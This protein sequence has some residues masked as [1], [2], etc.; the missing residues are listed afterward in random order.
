MST[1]NLHKRHK[2]EADKP[3]FRRLPSALSLKIVG[4]H[5]RARAS[6][7]TLPHGDVLTPVFM[8]VGTQGTI[9]GLTPEQMAAPPID[10]K[11][12][13]ANTYHLA[14]RPGTELVDSVGGIHEFMQWPRNVLTDSGGFQMVSL[15]KLCEITE[16]GVTFESF[17]DGTTMLLTPEMS[18]Q[19][20]NRIGSD[21]I[22]AL[23][24]VVSSVSDDTARF[25]EACDRT[26]RWIDRCMEAHANPERQN[27]FGIVQGGLDVSEGGLRD[28]CL[29][30]FI[31][32]DLPGY[33]IGGLAGGESK[34]DFWKVVAKCAARLPDNKPRYVMGVG[35]PL[36]LVVCSALGADMFDCV[37][38]TRTARFGT[39]IVPSGLLKLKSTGCEDDLRPIDETCSCFVC[40]RYTR[41]YLRLLL[42][43]DD[44][45]GAQLLTYHNVTYMLTLMRNLR[46]S[47]ID[48]NFEEFVQKFMLA[49]FPDKQYPQWAVDALTE[50]QIKLL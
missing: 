45:V 26:I 22:M 29:D 21:I 8:P 35:Y 47:I 34:D 5:H 42:R 11:I 15:S 38:P 13:L 31:E 36:D 24:D 10:C 16:E 27:L 43:K 2:T 48:G 19:H 1:E 17:V 37:W 12:L 39:A 3:T 41:A 20:Q 7:L 50:A 40:K 25:E 32:R 4:R 6:V 14:L 44:G 18:I 49:Q 9:K 28:R 30:A 23:D 33:A 46:Q